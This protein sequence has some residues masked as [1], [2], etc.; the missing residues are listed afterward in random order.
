MKGG[1]EG[2]GVWVYGC[3]GVCV[4]DFEQARRTFHKSGV[5][6]D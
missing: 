4:G 1:R 3:M 5:T 2:V 6:Y